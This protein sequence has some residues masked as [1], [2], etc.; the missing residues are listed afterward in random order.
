MRSITL[1]VVCLLLTMFALS[2]PAQAARSWF[3]STSPE[4]SP[5]PSAN[6]G[7]R[8]VYFSLLFYGPDW[9]NPGAYYAEETTH[10]SDYGQ[11]LKG[12]GYRYSNVV[13]HAEDTRDKAAG[14]KSRQKDL[15]RSLHYTI[16][17]VA[18]PN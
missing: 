11:W 18:W 16:Q 14:E 15:D 2:L 13:C 5:D 7:P 6:R 10:V 3:C 12:Q 1:F 9:T 17:E 4:L 8:P